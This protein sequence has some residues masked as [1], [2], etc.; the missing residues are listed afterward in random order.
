[1]IAQDMLGKLD[2]KPPIMTP[3]TPK[4]GIRMKPNGMP[5]KR[6]SKLCFIRSFVSPTPVRKLVTLRLPTTVSR[7]PTIAKANREGAKTYRS[8]NRVLIM[9]CARTIIAMVAGINNMDAYFTD[10]E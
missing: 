4:V 2:T 1:M 10:E 3:V 5:I 8:P 7:L 9:G 6:F